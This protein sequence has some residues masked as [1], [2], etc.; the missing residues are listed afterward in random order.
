MSDERGRPDSSKSRK[1]LLDEIYYLRDVAGEREE[2]IRRLRGADTEAGASAMAELDRVLHSRSWRWTAPLR[3]LTRALR[4]SRRPGPGILG[5]GVPPPAPSMPESQDRAETRVDRS[6]APSPAKA[7]EQ[8]ERHFYVDV[9]ELVLHHGRTGVQRVT[10]EIL[11]ALLATPPSGFTVR[12][13]CAPPGQPYQLA[14]LFRADAPGAADAATAVIDPRAGDVFLGLDHSMRAVAERASDLEA[15]RRSGVRIWFVCN[16]VLPLEHPEWF[17]EE[18]PP[19]FE[20]WLRVVLAVA[21]GVAC[22]SQAT[23]S[24]LRAR[25]ATID[26]SRGLPL[27]IVHFRLGADMPSGAGAGDV[28]PEE[29]AQLER[30]KG[31]TSFLVVGTL[32][33]RKGHAQALGAFDHLWASGENVALVLAGLPGWMTE[34]LQRRIRHHDEFGRRLFWFDDAS[35]AVLERLYSTCTAL[36]APSQ[37][38]GFGLPLVEAARHGLP[39]LCRDLPVFHEVAGDHA[40]YF[41]GLD[42]ACM[43]L[44]IRAWL[45]ARRTVIMP[46]PG[47]LDLCTWAESARQLARVI[48]K[49]PFCRLRQIEDAGR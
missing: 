34:V 45:Q 37:G 44:A 30:L 28:T 25:V 43:G 33:P 32:E 42:A 40:T 38:E 6:P 17:P 12:P 7:R 29:A 3:W 14:R 20:A 5:A 36:L 16:D 26:G 41:G 46:S 49:A 27:E 1:E 4:P 8:G 47:T 9:S 15:M 22:I 10:R 18:V 11:R 23:E 2:Q 39:I 19:R 48:L 13:V 21:D 35:D 24:A 31:L